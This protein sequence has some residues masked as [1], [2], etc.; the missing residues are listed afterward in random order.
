MFGA[1]GRGSN[2]QGANIERGEEEA[3]TRAVNHYLSIELRES[4][5]RS[6]R[7]ANAKNFLRKFL[8]RARE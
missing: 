4:R 3:S 1:L 6:L 5:A 8:K 7:R 2:L